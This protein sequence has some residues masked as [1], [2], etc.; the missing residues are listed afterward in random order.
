[1]KT[2]FLKTNLGLGDIILCN[3]LIRNVCKKY[4]HVTIFTKPIYYTS[5]KYMFRDI[6]NLSIL[7]KSDH[8]ASIFLKQ[9]P[10]NEKYF[11]GIPD[12]YKYTFDECFYRQIGLNFK[13]RWNDFYIERD[14][15]EETKVFLELAPKEPY[16]FVHD[17][18]KRGFYLDESFFNKKLKIFRPKEIENIFLYCTLI[19]NAQEIHCMD[20]CFKHIVDSLNIKHNNLFYHIYT[21]GFNNEGYTQSKLD[22]KKIL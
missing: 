15:I 9:V 3:G 21:R 14:M 22:W 10:D 1:M 2:L 16:V 7:E 5:V 13:K 4:Q 19:E 8:E 17:D 20:S 6:E 11:V 18:H 12:I